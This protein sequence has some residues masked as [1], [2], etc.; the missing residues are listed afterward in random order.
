MQFP[1]LH[2]PNPQSM[3][4]SETPQ[5]SLLMSI[6]RNQSLSK[7]EGVHEKKSHKRKKKKR[8][9][10]E[11]FEK[12][13]RAPIGFNTSSSPSHSSTSIAVNCISVTTSE[14]SRPFKKQKTKKANFIVQ[15]KWPKSQNSLPQIKKHLKDALLAKSVEFKINEECTS[16]AISP[17][18]S[19]IVGGFTDGTIRFFDLSYNKLWSRRLPRNQNNDD[20]ETEFSDHEDKNIISKEI[21]G[22]GNRAK[23]KLVC[24]RENQEYGSV[25]SQIHAKGVHTALIMHVDISPDC[26]FAFGGVMRGSTEMVAIDI[27]KLEK[28]RGKKN[29]NEDILD[30]IHVWKES[31]AKLRGFGACTRWESGYRLFCG[32]G[33]KVK[34]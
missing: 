28:S 25:T 31:D 27:S 14:T 1:S 23:H 11:S 2:L 24:S 29:K 20:E 22:S 33:I 15:G 30:L 19:I 18:G 32:R 13:N 10:V 8:E 17:S 9:K 26:K 16:L 34:N 12:N 7:T 5:T 21:F 4:I 6:H 3:G